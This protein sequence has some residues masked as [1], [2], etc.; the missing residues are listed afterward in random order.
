M[1]KPGAIRLFE[2]GAR[3]S[4]EDLL[5]RNLLIRSFEDEVDCGRSVRDR[6]AGSVRPVQSALL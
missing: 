3:T 4:A 2:R 1:C 5:I 6:R